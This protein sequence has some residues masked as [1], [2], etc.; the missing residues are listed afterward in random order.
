MTISIIFQA[1]VFMIFWLFLV[2]RLLIFFKFHFFAIF[3]NFNRYLISFTMF[4]MILMEIVAFSRILNYF[5]NILDVFS[6]ISFYWKFKFWYIFF[7][8]INFC[9][10]SKSNSHYVAEFSLKYFLNSKQSSKFLV[11]VNWDFKCQILIRIHFLH[12]YGSFWGR[13][14]A[15]SLFFRLKIFYKWNR[16]TMNFFYT[17]FFDHWLKPSVPNTH[18]MVRTSGPEASYPSSRSVG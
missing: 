8:F 11:L 17:K 5:Y 12:F 10:V 9:H 1:I 13:T 7:L 16:Y 15:Y 14:W 3:N 4:S 6:L 18:I 2:Y